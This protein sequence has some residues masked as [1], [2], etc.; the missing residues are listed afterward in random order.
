[1]E[2][3]KSFV[4]VLLN[5]EGKVE[6]SL[7][8]VNAKKFG[9]ITFFSFLLLSKSHWKVAKQWSLDL[10]HPINE[11]LFQI[12]GAAVLLQVFVILLHFG[13]T[14]NPTTSLKHWQMWS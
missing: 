10:I 8:S 4:G 11:F 2:Y 7:K 5:I 9:L 12:L 13:G 14:A 3:W 6:I 1:M